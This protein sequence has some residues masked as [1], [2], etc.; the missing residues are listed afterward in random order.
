[1][2]ELAEGQ[3]AR[4]K[5]EVQVTRKARRAL[6]LAVFAS[7]LAACGGG[8][9]DGGDPG[10]CQEYI[11]LGYTDA[12]AAWS[13]VGWSQP[14]W[15]GTLEAVR[16]DPSLRTCG[17]STTFR[18]INGA[19]PPG[20]TLD[21]ATG[22]I[23]GTPTDGGFYRVVIGARVTGYSGE[24]TTTLEFNVDDFGIRYSPTWNVNG[25]VGTPVNLTAVVDDGSFNDTF[26]TSTISN[27]RRGFILPPGT[28]TSYAVA[29][30]TLPPGLT[31]DAATGSVTGTPTAAGSYSVAVHAVATK[32][33]VAMAA[34]RDATLD[35][36]IA[37]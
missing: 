23:T 11:T 7:A 2:A 9:G 32:D 21:L 30:G 14:R 28:T 35:F 19:L 18:R 37:P 33:G 5:K 12:R 27:A 3:R 26:T 6:G 29:Q 31:L 8:G 36:D 1:M 22:V 20:V 17:G 24:A 13:T 15:F 16:F 4:E 25:R 10:G 34:D